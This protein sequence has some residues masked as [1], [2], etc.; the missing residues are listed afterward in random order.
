MAADAIIVSLG[1][2]QA[3]APAARREALREQPEPPPR[4]KPE[5]MIE[6]SSEPQMAPHSPPR[7][8]LRRVLFAFLPLT[9][10]VGAYW[11][12]TGGRVM[13]TDNAYVEADK[14]GISTD[15][16]AIVKEVDVENNQQVEEGA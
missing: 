4:D 6:S 8:W 15:V 5:P 14:V 13:S 10:I 9:L 12:V 16:S 3:D 7:R 11:Y 1:S 2:D